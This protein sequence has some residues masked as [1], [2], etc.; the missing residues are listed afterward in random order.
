MC[1]GIH[2]TVGAEDYKEEGSLAQVRLV[3]A[4]LASAAF[5]HVSENNPRILE[6]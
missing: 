5:Y 6:L 1:Q 3:A 2:F 4:F